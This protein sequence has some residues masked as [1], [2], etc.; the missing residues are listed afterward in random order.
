MTTAISTDR[1]RQRFAKWDADGTGT[2]ERSD[3]EREADRVAGAFGATPESREAKA[4]KDAMRGL[5]DYHAREAGVQ[6]SGSVSEDEFIRINEKLMFSD[7][8]ESFNQVLRPMM[9]ALSGLCD[10]NSDGT[11]NEQEFAQWLKGVGVD[12]STAR[13]AFHQIDTD[14]SGELTVEELLAAVRKFHTGE[15]DV[16]MLG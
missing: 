7:G 15:L 8:E 3:F 13:D 10:R 16:P 4:M 14:R 5:F 9:Q 11:L 6:S 1:L 12:E 2:L